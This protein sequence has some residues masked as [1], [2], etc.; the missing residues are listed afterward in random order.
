MTDAQRLNS[1]EKD[2]SSGHTLTMR[3]RLHDDR[4]DKPAVAPPRG[5]MFWALAPFL[6]VFLVLMPILVPHRNG[7]SLVVLCGVESAALA[8]LLG[9][10]N[11]HRFWW[12]W[13]ALGAIVFLAYLAYVGAMFVEGRFIGQGRRTET[14]L[15]NALLG[16]IAFGLPGLCYAIFGRL[17]WRKELIDD[18]YLDEVDEDDLESTQP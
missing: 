16:M 1:E 17:T 13:R 7:G 15:L 10:W 11:S 14:T 4:A 8:L 18:E 2:G 5:F 12:A 6:V 9:L 3:G